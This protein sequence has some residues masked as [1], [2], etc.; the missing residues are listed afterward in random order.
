MDGPLYEMWILFVVVYKVGKVLF[1]FFLTMESF[2]DVNRVVST[3]IANL[4]QAMNRTLYFLFEF[5]YYY[6]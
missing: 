6:Y 5:R 2:C 3:V 4:H 1:F